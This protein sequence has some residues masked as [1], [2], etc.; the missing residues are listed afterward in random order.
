MR[1]PES[2]RVGSFTKVS[3]L[4][5]SAW[6]HC[7]ITGHWKVVC[8]IDLLCFSCR[9]RDTELECARFGLSAEERERLRRGGCPRW[10]YGTQ[11]E[12]GNRRRDLVVWIGITKE[13]CANLIDGKRPRSC[14]QLFSAAD[15]M[16]QCHVGKMSSAEAVSRGS[17][18]GQ[19]FDKDA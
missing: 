17:P 2:K 4:M 16:Q 15:G 7:G 12:N 19:G 1:R 18:F 6:H 5:D 10:V 11:L 14:F 9:R 13:Q 8:S 3:A